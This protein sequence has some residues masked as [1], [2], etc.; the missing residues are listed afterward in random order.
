MATRLQKRKL[1][2]REESNELSNFV[3][4]ETTIAQL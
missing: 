4:N 1:S 2:E 3:K